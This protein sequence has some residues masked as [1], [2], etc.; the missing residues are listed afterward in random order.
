MYAYMRYVFNNAPVRYCGS[1]KTTKA[2]SVTANCSLVSVYQI[3]GTACS[4]SSFE[5]HKM[6]V[7][8]M[9]ENHEWLDNRMYFRTVASIM[10]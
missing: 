8:S 2:V 1:T 10:K 3:P 5:R 6:N 7:P 9:S 4:T